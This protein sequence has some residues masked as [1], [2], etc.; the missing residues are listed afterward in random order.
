MIWIVETLEAPQHLYLH[1][2]KD[3]ESRGGDRSC[4]NSLKAQS[5]FRF[6]CTGVYPVMCMQ[7]FLARVCQCAQPAMFF[8]HSEQFFVKYTNRPHAT[9]VNPL[10]RF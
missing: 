3:S 6:L 10:V 7:V 4:S 8:T 2:K 9:A 1:M 5:T